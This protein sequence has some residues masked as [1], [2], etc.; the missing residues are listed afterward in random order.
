M[1]AYVGS[2]TT[3]QRKARGHGIT[4]YRGEPGGNWTLLQAVI[5]AVNPTFL[6]MSTDRQFLYAVHI[7]ADCVTAY[8]VQPDG[9]LARLNQERIG[10][11]VLVAEAIDTVNRNLIVA[12]YAHGGVAVLPIGSE[13]RLGPRRQLLTFAG[14]PGPHRIQQIGSHPHDICIAP[15]G[16]FVLVPDK[17]LDRLF[18][19]RIASGGELAP[20]DAGGTVCRSG[21]GP[22]QLAFH[23]VLPICYLVNELDSTVTTYAWSPDSGAIW[24]IQVLPTLPSNYT[25]QNTAS[26]IAAAATGRFVYVSNRGHDAVCIF[27]VDQDQGTLQF[28]GGQSTNG[29]RPRFITFD[30]SGQF[31]FATNEGSDT[32]VSLLCD[33]WTGM[34]GSAQTCITTGSPACI[35]FTAP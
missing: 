9:T 27:A 6:A 18:V 22:R 26:G 17:G 20:V 10:G 7:D 28:I 29:R 4:V 16:R 33:A 34:L 12:N 5:D 30:P 13:G 1:L 25:A 11:D 15:D 32:V 8:A 19:L 31:L 21:A 3:S 35:I 2:F 14:S 23:P 24:P